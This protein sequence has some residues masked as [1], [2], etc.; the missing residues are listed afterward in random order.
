L[1]IEA[2]LEKWLAIAR[3]ARRNPETRAHCFTSDLALAEEIEGEE[4]LLV[5][6]APQWSAARFFEE[7]T[8]GKAAL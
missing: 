3:D 6:A 5:E 4:R 1:D 8:T 7:H 2:G